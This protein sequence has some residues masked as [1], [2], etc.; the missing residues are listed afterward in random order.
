M[1]GHLFPETVYASCHICHGTR[2]AF[3]APC[4]SCADPDLAVARI[5]LERLTPA[6]MA[7]LRAYG[8]TLA[9]QPVT[10]A[11]YDAHQ[12]EF[13]VGMGDAVYDDDDGDLLVPETRH[14]FAGGHFIIGAGARRAA[15]IRYNPLGLLLREC[16]MA[17]AD[18][19]VPSFS[20]AG[21]AA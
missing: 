8:H 5:A 12:I 3:G 14:W 2:E 11:E 10:A 20:T 18:A 15:F 19:N 9:E 17:G 16:L 4:T 13:F 7:F 1:S 6:Q 21:D